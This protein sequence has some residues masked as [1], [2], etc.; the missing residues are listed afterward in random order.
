[1]QRKAIRSAL[2]FTRASMLLK[3]VVSVCIQNSI[4]EAYTF[5]IW[6]DVCLFLWN[7]YFHFFSKSGDSEN[8]S[9]FC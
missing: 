8:E 4:H 7:F 5:E 3:D 9:G 2:T 1:M 6:L